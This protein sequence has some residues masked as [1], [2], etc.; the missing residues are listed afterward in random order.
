MT[1]F[2]PNL[3]PNKH[4]FWGST[5]GFSQGL[6]KGLNVNTKSKD[7]KSHLLA[8][9]Q[10]VAQYFGLNKE[11]LLLLNQGV[12]AKVEYITSPSQDIIWADGAV[13]DKPQIILCIRTADC[14]PVLL[15]DYKHGIIGAAHAGWRGAFSGIIQNT[16][17]LML[18]KGAEKSDISAAVG[19]CI[20]QSS[21]EVDHNFYNQFLDASSTNSQYFLTGKPQHYYFNLEKF[22]SDII[23]SCGIN[24]VVTSGIDTYTK[25]DEYYSFRRFTHQNLITEPKCFPTELSAITL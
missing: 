11:N 20:G 18:Q 22:C 15:A 12:S 6:Y 1:W 13:T 14:A 16:I 23:R 24:N 9:L 25:P 2:S 4:C 7:D 17:E 8:N 19:P 3:P 21:Y 5:G 10:Q